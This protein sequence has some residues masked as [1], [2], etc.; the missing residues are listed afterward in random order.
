MSTVSSAAAAASVSPFPGGL[1]GGLDLS[2]VHGKELTLY[3]TFHT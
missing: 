3:F 1:E 2:S